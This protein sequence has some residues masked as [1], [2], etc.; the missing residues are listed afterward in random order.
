MTSHN[1][2]TV[3]VSRNAVKLYE[4]I[5]S[6]RW[7]KSTELDDTVELTP[8]GVRHALA[9][10]DDSGV[11]QRN[12]GSPGIAG[13]VRRA[14]HNKVVKSHKQKAREEPAALYL[15]NGYEVSSCS[16]NQ[17]DTI[18]IHR[19]VAIAEYGF[20]AV[21]NSHVHHINSIPWDNRPSNL[22]PLSPSEHRRRESLRLLIENVPDD[23][24][25][26]ALEL[27]GYPEAA[28]AIGAATDGPPPS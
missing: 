22:I 12:N 13:K 21:E 5:P 28:E 23:V 3:Y 4:S 10:L 20:E 11:I 6:D 17:G 7:A 19:L 26:K 15:N 18:Q 14:A 9:K 2:D 25:A 16:L 8:R 24:L 1:T 27:K